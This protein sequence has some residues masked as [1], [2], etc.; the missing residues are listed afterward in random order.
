IFPT[1][2]EKRGF[3]EMAGRKPENRFDDGASDAKYRE[4]RERLRAVYEKCDENA[5]PLIERLVDDAVAWEVQLDMCRAEMESIEISPQT[6]AKY[7]Y[8]SKLAREA[9]QQY[10]NVVKVLLKSVRYDGL[11]GEDEFDEFLAQMRGEGS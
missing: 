7:A 3:L 1:K 11:G 10:T 2:S 9:Q 8:Y 6:K 5:Q 4:R